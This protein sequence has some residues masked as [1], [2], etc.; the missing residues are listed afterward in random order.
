MKMIG[1]GMKDRSILNINIWG[2]KV[3][4]STG[5]NSTNK[6]RFLNYFKSLSVHIV[7]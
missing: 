7:N 1:G 5:K 6:K 3:L 4:N 2:Q